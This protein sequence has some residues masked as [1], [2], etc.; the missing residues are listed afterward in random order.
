MFKVYI[1][2]KKLAEIYLKESAK[3]SAAT[4][5]NWFRILLRQAQL[6]TAGYS[7]PNSAPDDSDTSDEAI[8]WQ[9]QKNLQIELCPQD[10]FAQALSTAPER[11]LQHAGGVFYLDLSPAQARKIQK[12]Y[13]VIC[14]S[15]DKPFSTKC[16]TAEP[17]TYDYS[18]GHPAPGWNEV[19]EVP[20][21]APLNALCIID[22]NLFVYDGRPHPALGTEQTNGSDNVF[23]IL[24]S[25][26]PKMQKAEFHVTIF[27]EQRMMSLPNPNTGRR[28]DVMDRDFMEELSERLFSR[29]DDLHR[30]Y[31][32]VM[33][34]IAM[35]KRTRYFNDTHN[36]QIISNYFRVTSENG[37][38]TTDF[39]DG[40]VSIYSQQ[41][42]SFLYYSNGLRRLHS[43]CTADTAN[44]MTKVCSDFVDHWRQNAGTTDYWYACNMPERSF[45]NHKNRLFEQ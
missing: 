27:T 44:R 6:Y 34:L 29:V 38:N 28:E 3:S 2:A 17:A 14:Q 30:P 1:S 7:F 23:H 8:L 40:E 39:M 36:R 35:K 33:E 15:T 32:I 22:R 11:V 12:D 21:G 31:P 41:L 42:N 25:I 4:Q 20:H 26:L 5:S 13:G 43:D 10:E 24:D 9:L 45:M 37:L 19:M 16:L 18:K